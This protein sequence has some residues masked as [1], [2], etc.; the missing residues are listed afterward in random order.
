MLMRM[1]SRPVIF[2]GLM[3]LTLSSFA[4]SRTITG[5]VIDAQTNTPLSGVTVTL[6]NSTS[7]TQTNG[8]GKYSIVINDNRDVLIFSFVGYVS[9]EYRANNLAIIDVALE[10]SAES[11]SQAVVVGYG[12]L[13]KKEI[14]SAVA[15]LK[16]E[17]FRQ[18]GARNALDLAQG[19]VAGLQITRS[20]SNPN[21]GV[22]IQIRGINSLTAGTSPLI[23]IDGI[24]GGNLDLLQQDDVESID[25]L[26]DG[27]AAAI[28]G[29]RGNGG[30]ILVTTKRGKAG[31]A[32]YNYNT[33]ARRDFVN[34]RLD[35]FTAEQI[36]SLISEGKLAA[37]LDNPAWGGASTD[38][39][40]AVLNKENLS[41]YHNLAISGGSKNMN[42]RASLYYQVLEGIALENARN[43]Y[44]A[45]FNLNH[46]GFND[47]LSTSVNFTTNYNKAN[48]L[49]NNIS[50]EGVLTRLPTQ[51]IYNADGSF[52]E[53]ANVSAPPNYVAM[54]NQEKYNRDQQT[55]SLDVKFTLELLKGLKA[56]IFGAIQRNS[57]I[58]NEYKSKASRASMIGTINNV[59]PAGDG[60]AYKSAFLNNNYA[61]E[62][63]IEYRTSFSNHTVTAIA[64]YSYRYE[65]EE[66]FGMANTGYVNDLYENNN[67]GAGRYLEAGKGYMTSNKFDN[68]L[69]AF[70]GRVTYSFNDRY[71]VQAIMRREGSS[72]FG[73]N[74]KWANF[75][76]VS[77]GWNLSRENFMSTVTW[78]D[79]LKLRV[80]YGITGNTG[81]ANYAS[82]VTLGGGGFYLYPDG[83]WRQTYGPNRNPNP[84]LR[85]ERKKEIN[86]GLD[87]SLLKGRLSGSLDVYQRRTEDLLDTY[88]SQLPGFITETVYANVGTM[89]N[90]GIE[91]TLTGVIIDSKNFEWKSTVAAS[92]MSNRMV[93]FSNDMFKGTYKEYGAIGG[94]GALGNAVRLVE[95]G[96]I[97]NFYG[98]RFAGVDEN[99]DWLFFNRKNEAVPSS[100]INTSN[101]PEVTDL[102]VIGNGIPRYYLSWNHSFRYKNFDANLFFRGKFKYDVLNLVEMAYTNT[103][104]P[105]NLLTSTFEKHAP[106]YSGAGSPSYQYSDYYI[107]RGDYFKLDEVTIGYTFKMRNDWIKNMRVYVGG[108][109]LVLMTRYSGN[110]PDFINDTGLAAGMDGRGVYPNTRSFLVGLNLGF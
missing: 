48:L 5:A 85:W 61:F 103:R 50:W 21:S 109:N 31:I 60:Y 40:N 64:G 16:P 74:N 76:A 65:V 49:G 53:D 100:Q 102:A 57:Y 9:Q 83:Q 44:G 39:F 35:F 73:A 87:Y 47:R 25:V 63:T 24:P 54:L 97:G 55:T 34:K 68:T 81:F 2:I 79:D 110:D 71:F 45:R 91:L 99:G 106:L 41:H 3:L 18:S 52:Y 29:T 30:V 14:T 13:Q 89:E 15:S 86:I 66:N 70:F 33:Y 37:T 43:N 51:P 84:N 19:K 28:Y 27:S 96:K 46:K 78:V 92:T 12:T 67:M 10:P 56:N 8:E 62:P 4:Q 93:T 94:Y 1:T 36:R 26:K 80:G 58:D 7:S 72:R 38:M 22:N 101:D 17:D 98:K 23:V 88:T 108:S 82:L 107:E 90:K 77:A 6:R 104:T 95:G 105:T 42:Y 75:P 59:T 69:I 11:L 20:S 32:Q